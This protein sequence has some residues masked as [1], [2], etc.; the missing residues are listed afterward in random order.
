MIRPMSRPKIQ[1]LP[2]WSGE[3]V[4][5]LGGG[6]SLRDFDWGQLVGR[7][8]IGCNAAYRHGAEICNID[9]F[10]DARF[11][12]S[13][14][15]DIENS[16]TGWLV[17]NYTVFEWF[18]P[19]KQTDMGKVP[20]WAKYFPR[21][22]IGLAGPGENALGWNHNTG[23]LAINLALK[24][25]A[26]RVLLLGFDC[27]NGTE[28]EPLRTHWHDDPLEPQDRYRLHYP[29]FILGFENVKAAL[30]ETY[31]DAEIL[32][33]TDG[34]SELYTFPRIGYA[35]AGLREPSRLRI[36]RS[37]TALGDVLTG[38]GGFAASQPLR[39]A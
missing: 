11:W 34:Y 35:E 5:I 29:N 37:E 20:P 19:F 31:P 18:N 36:P 12:A 39:G 26:K 28:T 6:P 10:G 16:Y 8:T 4:Y 33:V 2:D 24:L 21:R 7:N 17:T 30:P 25:G 3:D 27:R 13:A 22:D 38:S 15:Y 1:P 14:G 9:C 23:A 32:N